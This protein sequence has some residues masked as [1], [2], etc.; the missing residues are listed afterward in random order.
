MRRGRESR[1]GCLQT[2]HDRGPRTT[3]SPRF[4]YLSYQGGKG[5]GP[6]AAGLGSAGGRAGDGPPN[7]SKS[8]RSAIG[9]RISGLLLRGLLTIRDTG[10]KAIASAG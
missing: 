7:Q 10:V 2:T 9:R 6:P 5:L 4:R 8:D 1:S 3:R